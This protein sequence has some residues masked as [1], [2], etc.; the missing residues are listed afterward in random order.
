[1]PYK[2][3]NLWWY[4]LSYFTQHNDFPFY[5]FLENV[6]QMFSLS[7]CMIFH[8]VCAPYFPQLLSW[9]WALR[10]TPLLGYVNSAM[11]CMPKLDSVFWFLQ[12]IK[13][14][15]PDCFFCLDTSSIC[16]TG[17]SHW[18]TFFSVLWYFYLNLYFCVVFTFH[19]VLLLTLIIL[20]FP[21][22]EKVQGQLIQMLLSSW[23]H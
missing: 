16:P 11:V 4:F 18:E 22:A 8:C 9:W 3:Q 14:L 5:V 23:S 10:L 12:G 6:M 13:N 7:D 20:L 2:R 17:T 19:V 21:A 1:M 15:R